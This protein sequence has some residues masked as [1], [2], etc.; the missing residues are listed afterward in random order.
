M[1]RKGTTPRGGKSIRAI[2][3]EAIRKEKEEEKRLADELAAKFP[4][5]VRGETPDPLAYVPLNLDAM[6]RAKDVREIFEQNGI[7]S[8]RQLFGTWDLVTSGTLDNYRHTVFKHPNDLVRRYNKGGI[9]AYTKILYDYVGK[10]Y[11]AYV[12]VS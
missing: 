10:L 7:G 3:N 1:K 11:H 8:W 6:P 9:L 5:I 4:G 2:R 12:D